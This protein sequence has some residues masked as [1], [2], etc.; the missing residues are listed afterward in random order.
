M[1]RV[2]VTGLGVVSALGIGCDNHWAG[3]L[4]GRNGI[5]PIT[6]FSC[7]GFS[8]SLGATVAGV[9]PTATAFALLAARE[10]IA[11]ANIDVVTLASAR[12]GFVL[13]ATPTLIM[14]H[15]H[16]VA[17]GIADALGIGGPSLCV[18]TACT[19]ATIAFGLALDLLRDELLDVVVAGGADALAPE[20]YAGFDRLGVICPAPCAPFSSP[21]GMT[22]GEGA[23]FFVL[24]RA[25]DRRRRGA[26]A[27]VELAGF[28]SSADAYHETAPIPS[29]AGVARAIRVA[30]RDADVDAADVGAVTAHGT[31]T[32]QNDAA[33]VRGIRA[34]LGAGADDV[35]ISASKSVFGHALAAAGALEA[36]TTALALAAG[37]VVPTHHFVGP[38]LGA[39]VDAVA[40]LT[41]RP[42]RHRHA[43]TT[44]SAFGGSNA[45]LVLSLVDDDADDDDARAPR[46]SRGGRASRRVRPSHPSRNGTWG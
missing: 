6:R 42:H 37:V 31:G 4:S 13:G 10:A 44:N 9:E 45:A 28:G 25:A 32:E 1:H 46:T 15:A 24:E 33:E 12:T 11:Q 19:S 8:S 29:G 40:G 22:P 17:Q 16:V 2:E 35:P 34:A 36:V 14:G 7:A 38:R 18:S 26:R 3:L 30:L 39:P 41:P 43:V 23:G 20:T 27:I 5:A 21:P